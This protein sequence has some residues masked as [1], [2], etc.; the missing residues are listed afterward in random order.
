VT[1][2][3]KNREYV[4]IEENKEIIMKVFFVGFQDFKGFSYSQE[5]QETFQKQ[6]G[7]IF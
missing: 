1:V 4:T 6:T 7:E 3:V 5:Q 2:T